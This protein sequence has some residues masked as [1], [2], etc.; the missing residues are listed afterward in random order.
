MVLN[1]LHSEW[2]KPWW[3]LAFLAPIGLIVKFYCL[4]SLFQLDVV[5][6]SL[7][8]GSIRVPECVTLPSIPESILSRTLK[9]L[10]IV[11]DLFLKPFDQVIK[12]ELHPLSQEVKTINQI[13]QRYIICKEIIYRKWFPS[14]WKADFHL[15]W[16]ALLPCPPTRA[17][18]LTHKGA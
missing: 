13:L 11:S 6:V 16:R 7:Y 18:P 2:P 4:Y 3:V 1:L 9:A 5:I 17:L 15:H 10:H 8:G 14:L 12:I